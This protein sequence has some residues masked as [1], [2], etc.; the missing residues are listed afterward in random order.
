[1][2]FSLWHCQG[3]LVFARVVLSQG[4]GCAVYI[5]LILLVCKGI[6]V[7]NFEVPFFRLCTIQ[8]SHRD[9]YIHGTHTATTNEQSQD[10]HTHT[11]TTCMRTRPPRAHS[12]LLTYVYDN[13]PPAKRCT[14][15]SLSQSRLQSLQGS[16]PQH[17]FQQLCM[18]SATEFHLSAFSCPDPDALLS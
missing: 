3:Y 10:A 1:M 14:V 9:Q 6:A 12:A 15:P 13:R 5:Y 4:G 17:F 11:H 8:T 7:Q 16:E 18:A 2:L